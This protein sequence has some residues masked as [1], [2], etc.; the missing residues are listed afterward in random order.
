MKLKIFIMAFSLVACTFFVGCNS[1]DETPNQAEIVGFWTYVSHTM[2]L[3]ING[4]DIVTFLIEDMQMQPAQA[5]IYKN[6]V[7]GML[8][9]D[10]FQ[11]TTV[12]FNANGTFESTEPDGSKETGTYELL[13]NGRRLVTTS[14]E[15]VTEFDV[16]TLTNNQLV[17]AFSETED[18]DFDDDGTADVLQM[19]LTM[20]FSK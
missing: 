3:N 1:D 17:I 4:K 11:G 7:L 16:K 14:S 5:E 9:E 6:V 18:I 13:D 20:T 10:Q 8:G 15:G 19:D 12:R 2:D